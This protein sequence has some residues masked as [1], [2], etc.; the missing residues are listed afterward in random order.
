MQPD[1]IIFD[2]DGVL[3]DSEPI[4]ARILAEMLSEIGLPTT[5][6]EADRRYRGR[7]MESCLQLVER[8]LGAAAPEDFEEQLH[9]R[10]SAVF[11]TE[12]RP[13]PGVEGV[14]RELTLPYCVA[15]SG[16]HAKM[17][18]TLTAT[19]LLSWFEGRLFSATEVERGKPFPDLFLH[20]A[21]RMS[22]APGRCLVIEDSVVG[23]A[24]A[25]AAGM[26]VLG[27]VPAGDPSGLAA[28]GS[29]IFR[30][31]SELPLLLRSAEL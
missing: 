15:S 18:T 21:E 6:A 24:A 7:S 14:L 12:L 16:S 28:A 20:A 29:R 25:R 10:T 27:Y 11:A 31:M 5:P 2:C 3:V 4:S 8:A 23:V 13:V 30:R 17:G 22:A 1:L 9:R 19:G 26:A